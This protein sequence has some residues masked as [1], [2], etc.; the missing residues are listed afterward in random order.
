MSVDQIRERVHEVPFRPFAVVTSSGHKYPVPHT[1]F[2]FL[3]RRI[4]IVA[5]PK[6]YTTGLAPLHIVALEDRPA[7][8]NGAQDRRR[9]RT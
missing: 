1:D 4:V 3:T 2:I 6:G 5:N 7:R 8:T 9:P